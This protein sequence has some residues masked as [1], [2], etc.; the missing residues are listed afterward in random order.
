MAKKAAAKFFGGA[1]VPARPTSKPAQP[2]NKIIVALTV[3]EI[4]N[5]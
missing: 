3:Q 5:E 4:L 2:S 1:S